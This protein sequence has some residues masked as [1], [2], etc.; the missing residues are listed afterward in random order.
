MGCVQATA[1]RRRKQAKGG[2]KHI[3]KLRRPH[4]TKRDAETAKQRLSK[5]IERQRLIQSRKGKK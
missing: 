2:Y 5:L 3:S 1:R 4:Y